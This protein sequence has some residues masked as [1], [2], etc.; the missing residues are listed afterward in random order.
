MYSVALFKYS[1]SVFYICSLSSYTLIQSN[2]TSIHPVLSYFGNKISDLP[3]DNYLYSWSY[4]QQKLAITVRFYIPKR[5]QYPYIG[6][7]EVVNV[8]LKC[9][10]SLT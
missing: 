10:D 2:L 1:V 9:W 8:Y 7:S 4:L 3:F 5:L 6:V